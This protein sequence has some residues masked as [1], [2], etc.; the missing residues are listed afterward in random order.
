M[1]IVLH[2]S[3]CNS[4]NENEKIIEKKDTVLKKT[5]TEIT[6]PKNEDSLKEAKR[7]FQQKY[8]QKE[9]RNDLKDSITVSEYSISKCIK[10]CERVDQV[11]KSDFK[12]ERLKLKIGIKFNCS[13]ESTEYVL[14][15]VKG[16]TLLLDFSR[17]PEEIVKD[18]N[19]EEVNVISVTKCDCYYNVDLIVIGLKFSP[20]K[21]KVNGTLLANNN[22]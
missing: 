4:S 12:N 8:R 21:I 2:F 19:G 9:K 14:A 13:F 16:E 20:K 5:N 15:S 22:R 1:T 11:I 3:S 17:A 18:K 10:D 6:V 7:I